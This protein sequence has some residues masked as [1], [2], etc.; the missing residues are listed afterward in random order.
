MTDICLPELAFQP[1]DTVQHSQDNARKSDTLSF[2]GSAAAAS[3]KRGQSVSRD[4]NA[5]TQQEE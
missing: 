2:A 1:H 5:H 3:D 4:S